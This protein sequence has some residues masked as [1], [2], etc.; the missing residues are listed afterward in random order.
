M[1]RINTNVQSLIAQRALNNNTGSLNQALERLST[2]LRI[3]RGK[4]DPAGLIAS[5]NLR[6][7][8]RST[9][10]AISNAERA[11]QVVN[12]AEGGLQ[13]VSGLLTELQGLLPPPPRARPER[14]RE[15]GQ[16]T[17]DRLH[18]PDRRPHRLLHLLQSLKLLNG[19]FD[20]RSPASPPASPTT[21][22]R[23]QVQRRSS[24][25]PS[26]HQSA[27]RAGLYLLRHSASTSPPAP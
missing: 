1:S 11:D 20:F 2:G 10:A 3:A 21:R 16:P 23:R 17:P 5:E 12:I 19:S 15:A 4:D 25:S 9:T 18:P 24:A 14:R 27:Q 7:E 26:D 8:L 6:S 13:E 22:S